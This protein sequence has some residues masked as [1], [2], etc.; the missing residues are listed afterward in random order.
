MTEQIDYFFS[1]GSPWAYI[2]LQDFLSLAARHGAEIRPHL[3]PL[4]LENGGIYS[5]ERPAPR[6]AYWIQ[7]LK[8]WA[9]LRGLR[10]QLTGR[11]GLSDP[12]PAGR[13]VAAAWVKGQDWA[14]LTG[15][16]Q[17]AFWAHAEDI[18]NPLRRIALAEA[19]GFDGAAL[20]AAAGAPD[21]TRHLETSLQAARQTGVFGVPTYAHRGELFWGQDS[22][23]FLDRQLS[24]QR[25]IA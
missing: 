10:L 9:H 12:T 19:A 17:S 11:E 8:R 3:I 14:H 2:G 16:L 18:G 21:I 24:G 20:E 7:D 25:L 4:I 13:M 1:I 6:R 15:V 5:R 23:P 22:L